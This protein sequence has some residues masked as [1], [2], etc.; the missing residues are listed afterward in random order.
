MNETPNLEGLVSDW[1]K[2]NGYDG[3]Y[4][5]CGECAC[6][7]SDLAPCENPNFDRC[8]AGYIQDPAGYGDGQAEWEP[9]YEWLVGAEPPRTRVQAAFRDKIR[10]DNGMD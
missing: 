10:K 7:S 3:L 6:L 9:E 8:K 2:K 1:L 5:T 4:N